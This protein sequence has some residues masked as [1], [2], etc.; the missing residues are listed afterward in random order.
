MARD[1][2]GLAIRSKVDYMVRPER[3]TNEPINTPS[4]H[5][6]GRT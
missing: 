2:M 6:P 1:A 3:R 4:A 5:P